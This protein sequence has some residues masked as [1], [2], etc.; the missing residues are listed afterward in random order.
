MTKF[1]LDH[2]FSVQCSG[3][4]DSEFY[5]CPCLFPNFGASSRLWPGQQSIWPLREPSDKV[6]FVPEPS[7][8]DAEIQVS[9]VPSPCNHMHPYCQRIPS[10]QLPLGCQLLCFQ[11]WPWC[12]S[13]VRLGFTFL[14]SAF[15]PATCFFVVYLGEC[16]MQSIISRENRGW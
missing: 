2:S 5:S 14:S 12:L 10:T 7:A 4:R 8:S 13:H 15:I 6:C 9:P 11:G 16:L 3:V 1:P